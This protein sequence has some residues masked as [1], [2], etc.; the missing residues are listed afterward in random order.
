I[1]RILAENAAGSAKRRA[2][3]LVSRNNLRTTIR[4]T[5]GKLHYTIESSSC[6]QAL[7]ERRLSEDH[8]VGCLSALTLSIPAGGRRVR[9]LLRLRFHHLK[10]TFMSFLGTSVVMHLPD[11][12]ARSFHV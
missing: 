8:S 12:Y 7:F 10:K 9:H 4:R 5:V 6:V 2:P 3:H 1:A 11:L